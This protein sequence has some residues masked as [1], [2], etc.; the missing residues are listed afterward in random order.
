MNFSVIS[1]TTPAAIVAP[2]SLKANLPSSGKSWNV[3]TGSGRT[4]LI[5][6]IAESPSF[7]NFGSF[8]S[9]APDCGFIF[10]SNATIVA[11][12]CAVCACITG[13]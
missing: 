1:F 12:T 2:M 13:V 5:L 9:I 7:R 8:Y 4:G 6:T 11:A 10:A 3:S